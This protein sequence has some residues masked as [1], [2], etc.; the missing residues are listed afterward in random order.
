MAGS[1]LS[2]ECLF[3]KGVWFQH[4][5]FGAHLLRAAKERIWLVDRV[6]RRHVVELQTARNTEPMWSLY[7]RTGQWLCGV[8]GN[9]SGQNNFFLERGQKCKGDLGTRD[10]E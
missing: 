8:N 6:A 2:V 7:V 9:A 1:A 5:S 4:H 3:L 10:D